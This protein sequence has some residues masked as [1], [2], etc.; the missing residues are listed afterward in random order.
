MPKHIKARDLNPN[1]YKSPIIVRCNSN[2]NKVK[3]TIKDNETKII[4]KKSGKININK[5][6]FS[7]NVRNINKILSQRMKKY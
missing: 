4:S 7:K 1:T 2:I 3:K 5:N 6:I